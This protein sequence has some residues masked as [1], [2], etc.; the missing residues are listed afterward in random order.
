MA[1]DRFVSL[2]PTTGLLESKAG[3][4]TNTPNAIVA[5]DGTGKLAGVQ[6][7]TGFTDDVLIGV[8]ISETIASGDFVELYDAAGTL[9][10]RKASAKTAALREAKAFVTVGAAFPS[11]GVV[12]VHF[13]GA[14]TAT[15]AAAS[16]AILAGGPV[17]LDPD[18]TSGA[19]GK[20]VAAPPAG[21][22]Y[23]QFLGFARTAS[24]GG[25]A[26][27]EVGVY[28]NRPVGVV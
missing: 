15:T 3:A 13:T 21:P 19:T 16:G 11:P 5:L 22:D 2:N 7:P 20:V 28:M 14:N 25:G 18:T 9:T 26:T 10:V 6:M 17:Y 1:A 24:A 8:A 23:T 4:V 12:D 27:V